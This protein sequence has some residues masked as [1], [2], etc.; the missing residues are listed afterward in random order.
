VFRFTIQAR[1]ANNAVVSRA[2]DLSIALAPIPAGG[3]R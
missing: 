1:D 3:R 2:F